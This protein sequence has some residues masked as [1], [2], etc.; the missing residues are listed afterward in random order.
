[1]QIGDGYLEETKLNVGLGVMAVYRGV[2]CGFPKVGG[3]I[4]ML[5]GKGYICCSNGV[6]TVA[7]CDVMN[8][9]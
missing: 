7:M 1:M 5:V 3:G 8:G 2:V 6:L 4:R 9:F